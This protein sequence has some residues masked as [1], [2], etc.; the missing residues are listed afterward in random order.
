M[1]SSLN[2][3]GP[4]LLILCCVGRK[5]SAPEMQLCRVI[6]HG[7]HIAE[8]PARHRICSR[9]PAKMLNARDRVVASGAAAC[10]QDRPIILCYSSVVQMAPMPTSEEYRMKAQECRRLANESRDQVEREAL[11]RMAAQWGRL[12]DHKGRKE[13]EEA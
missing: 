1:V 9:F 5:A 3:N 7:A 6:E 13:A 11:L 10:R 4:T 12:A 8:K 2:P